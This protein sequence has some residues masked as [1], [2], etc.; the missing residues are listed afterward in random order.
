MAIAPYLQGITAQILINGVPTE[1]YDDPDPIAPK[2]ADPA[3]ARYISKHTISKYIVSETNQVFSIKLLVA[4]PY[5]NIMDSKCG[6]HIVIDGVPAWTSTCAR[7]RV[8]ENGG[9]WEDEVMG[10]KVGKGRNCVVRNFRFAEITTNGNTPEIA[11]VKRMAQQLQKIGV[12]EIKVYRE[13]YGILGGATPGDSSKFLNNKETDVPEKALKGGDAKT[14]GTVLGKAQK[15][16]R[17][18]VWTTQKKD[19]DDH[20]L[21]VFRFMYRSLDALKQLQV[22][23]RTPSPSPSVSSSFSESELSSRQSSPA[24]EEEP[25][26]LTA[27]QNPQ[28]EELMARFKAENQGRRSVSAEQGKV[29]SK[30]RNMK[31]IKKEHLEDREPRK[32]RRASEKAKHEQVDFTAED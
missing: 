1:E 25:G 6:F 15:T 12:I 26:A 8:K 9:T 14:H 32:R 7:P 13:N 23:P 28:M 2:H 27:E 4:K 16:M 3:V 19:G 31:R 24:P 18:T 17:G 29:G 5:S 21:V 20:P 11:K 30:K 10:V 22:I